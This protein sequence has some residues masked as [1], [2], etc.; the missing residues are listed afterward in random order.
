[1]RNI[2]RT[3]KFH[4]AFK[5]FVADLERYGGLA[6]NYGLN[7][8]KYMPKAGDYFRSIN[9]MLW[10]NIDE[11]YAELIFSESSPYTFGGPLPPSVYS[12]RKI[13]VDYACE[14]NQVTA[15]GDGRANQI[16]VAN[17]GNI[18][19]S[20]VRPDFT[21]FFTEKDNTC[22]GDPRC[23]IIQAF[24]SSDTRPWYY[25]CTVKFGQTVNDPDKRS[26]ISDRMAYVA[27]SSIAQMGYADDRGQEAQ[28]YP[29]NSLWGLLLNG[30][31]AQMG[32]TVATFALGSLAGASLFNPA[33][34]FAGAAPSEGFRLDVRHPK[35]FYLLIG[36][37][38]GSQFL[39][40]VVV[41]VLSNRVMVGPDSHLDMALLLRPIA[42]ALEGVSNGKNNSAFRDA[43]RDTMVRYE[44]ARNGRWILNMHL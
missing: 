19:V 8:T 5:N 9:A 11:N 14:S 12:A 27:G 17:V 16:T 13:R 24:E 33:R 26:Q 1:M 28:Y 44:K 10:F 20:H 41:A 32:Q 4:V 37:I 6:Y 23:S 36:L 2:W 15:G 40:C 21:T 18:N 30:D 42:D 29:R 25:R 3:C 31:E 43:K 39:F 22:V 35:F 34:F 38:C 7:E